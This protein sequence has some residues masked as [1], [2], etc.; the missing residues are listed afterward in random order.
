MNPAVGWT[1]AL[2]AVALG[3]TQWGW[4]GVVLA[5][6]CVVFWLLLQFSRALRVMR[7][8]AA[9]P[10][11]SVGSA[12]MLHARLR[13]GMRL[14]EVIPLAGSLGR[15]G[16]DGL[17]GPGS[18]DNPAE[19]IGSQEVFVWEDASQVAVRLE[20]SRGRLQRWTLQRPQPEPPPPREEPGPAGERSSQ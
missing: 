4:P 3:Y 18:P 5:I 19:G 1:L 10:V 13:Q 7:Q 17:S 6:T 9:A 8:A 2:L 20:F 16:R 15:Q 11:G 12:V 14:L